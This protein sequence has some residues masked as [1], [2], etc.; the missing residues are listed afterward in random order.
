MIYKVTVTY[1]LDSLIAAGSK[2]AASRMARKTVEE[3]HLTLDDF[4]LKIEVKDA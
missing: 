2:A 1:T 3:G 4:E